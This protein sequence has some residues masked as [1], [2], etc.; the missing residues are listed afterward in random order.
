MSD[1]AATSQRQQAQQQGLFIS[2]LT[3]PFRLIGVLFGS[4]IL[5]IAIECAGM[6]FFWPE[7]GWYHSRRMF[8]FELAQ[9]SKDFTRSALVQEPGRTAQALVLK[10]HEIV[11]VKTGIADSLQDTSNKARNAQNDRVHSGRY[12][13]G[14]I[15]TY[16]ENGLIAAA[17]TVLVFIVRLLVLALTL[18][19]FVTTAFVGLVDGL[20]CRDIRRFGA[21]RE[22]GYIYHR[23]KA[24]VIPLIIWPWILYLALPVSLD[25][26]LILLP[27]AA[28]LGVVV[29][30]TASRFKKYL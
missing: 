11:L 6:Y 3:L 7:E 28:L 2:L 25:A 19:L 27:S 8:E 17:Y 20:V 22:S 1:P 16:L 30:L 9:M 10:V 4:L 21:G 14:T 23:A 5:S 29:A 24:C 12:Y 18:P 26:V 13:L 15:Y